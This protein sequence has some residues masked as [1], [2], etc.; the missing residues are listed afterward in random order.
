MI[1]NEINLLHF[2]SYCQ[3]NQ[4]LILLIVYTINI[5]CNVIALSTFALLFRQK[6]FFISALSSLS[7]EMYIIGLETTYN[8]TAKCLIVINTSSLS[9][10][11]STDNVPINKINITVIMF[12][13]ITSWMLP[14]N[15]SSRFTFSDSTPNC[16][17]LDLILATCLF[18]TDIL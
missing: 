14:F 16:N 17:L 13:L 10:C 7:T 15:D 6:I 9:D 8:E 1:Q 18:R 12:S 11:A 2:E 3:S 4:L 5:R